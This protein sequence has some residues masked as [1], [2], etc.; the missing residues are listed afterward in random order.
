M[1]RSLVR[2]GLPISISTYIFIDLHHPTKLK[3]ILPVLYMFSSRRSCVLLAQIIIDCA[4]PV[5]AIDTINEFA[6]GLHEPLE[7]S[8]LTN[9]S[10]KM[11][12]VIYNDQP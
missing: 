4:P 5:A 12:I 3:Y 11:N 10:I 9:N 7:L 1:R 2:A 6:N 8:I